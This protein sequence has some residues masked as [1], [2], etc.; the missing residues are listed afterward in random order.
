MEVDGF[1]ALE[2]RLLEEAVRKDPE[3]AGL[4]LSEEFCEFGSSG[5][6]YSKTQLLAALAAEMPREGLPQMEDFT[7]E[8]VKEGVVLV[9]YKSVRRRTDGS[10][11]RRALRSSLWV[12][13][14][15]TWRVRFHQGTPLDED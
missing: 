8:Q 2:G 14:G 5:R 6:V 12:R 3:E 4:L 9:T 15:E 1:R 7:A 10:V 11:Q 13:E